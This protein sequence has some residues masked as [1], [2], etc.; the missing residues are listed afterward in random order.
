MTIPAD[1]L[2]P[3]VLLDKD[4]TRRFF[5]G[6]RPISVA[7]LYRAIAKK[8]I[9]PPIKVVGSSRWILSECEE[10]RSAMI[11]RRDGGLT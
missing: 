11:A 1:Q 2:S 10:A 4:A 9:P 8:I 5:G 6:T 7:T 3:A